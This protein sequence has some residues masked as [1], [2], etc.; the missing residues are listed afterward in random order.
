M[1]KNIGNNINNMKKNINNIGNNMENNIRNPVVKD[2]FYE[3]EKDKL[4]SQIKECFL[5]KFGPKELPKKNNLYNISST[6]NVISSIVPHAGYTC[7]G[8]CAAFVYLELSNRIKS[9]SES[10][11]NTVIIIGT[12]HTGHGSGI[13][14][15]DWKTPLGIVKV[16]KEFCKTLIEDPNS[17]LIINEVSH[18]NEHSI[19]VQLPFLQYIYN[20]IHGQDFKIVPIVIS[21]E[22]NYEKVANDIFKI[23]SKNLEQKNFTIIVSGDFVHYGP[24]Y[25]YV[26]FG[27]CINEK[28]KE[29]IT[30]IQ[31]LDNKAINFILNNDSKGFTEFL[32]KTNAT[33][34]GRFGFN[35][36][37]KL[38]K[39]FKL[40]GKLLKYETSGNVFKDYSNSVSYAS[41][42]FE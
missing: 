6:K 5:S 4:V 12:D 41:I 36:L 8:M 13:S 18:T 10:R 20:H 19:E 32:N 24:A 16:D 31:K 35:M 17:G 28:N 2:K 22:I 37:I 38:N 40:K 25:E 26:P 3:A 30:K 1:E 15:M 11:E 21:N 29:I 39:L 34:C 7:S 9:T 14:M 23:V 42:L 27:E 33:I